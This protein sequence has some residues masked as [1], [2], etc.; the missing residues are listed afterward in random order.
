VLFIIDKDGAILEP[1]IV[2]SV[3]YSLDEE[4]L[5]ILQISPKWV[6]A[7]IGGNPVKVT[8]DSL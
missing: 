5:R 4:L 8:S 2:K 6:P 3:E 7:R 1:E